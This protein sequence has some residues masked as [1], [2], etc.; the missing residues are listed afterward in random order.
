VLQDGVLS[1]Y[2]IHGPD[3][4]VINPETEK[5]FKVIGDESMRIISRNRSSH[6]SQHQRKAFGEIHLKVP[7]LIDVLFIF[8]SHVRVFFF[9]N[10]EVHN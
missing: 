1:Y 5:G 7:L 6:H 8:F 9:L 2:K 4:I 3:K 10:V